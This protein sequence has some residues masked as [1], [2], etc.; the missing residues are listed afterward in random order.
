MIPLNHRGISSMIVL[1]LTVLIL[2]VFWEA[3]EFIQIWGESGMIS[4]PESATESASLSC[5]TGDPLDCFDQRN[6]T[7]TEC[8]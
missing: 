8:K 7:T 3:G 2:L 4:P 5:P 6:C 1:V